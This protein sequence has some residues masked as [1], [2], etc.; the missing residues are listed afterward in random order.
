MLYDTH[1]H[2]DYPDFAN[3]LPEIIARANEA[4]VTRI[5]TIGT[6][7]ESSRRALQLAEMHPNIFA[8]IGWHPS[9]AARAPCDVRAELRALGRHEKVV[10]IG[11]IGLDYYRLPSKKEGGDAAA[12][13][14]YKAKQ[15]QVFRQQL[16]LA[17]ELGLNCV[18]HQRDSFADTIQE[19]ERFTGRIRTV[20]HC[21]AGAPAEMERVLATN[22]L[23]SFTGIVTF[24][25]AAAV[26]ETVRS[27]PTDR[28]MIETDSPF[29]APVPYRGKRCEPAYVSYV[30]ET[31]GQIKGLSVPALGEAT[32]KTAQAFFRGLK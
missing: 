8:T 19:V 2:L 3:E 10:A 32:C 1:A 22:S 24:K 13:E 25:N 7:L 27:V 21:F 14:A 26:R 6:D 31:I 16:E 20:F 28:F 15:M 4:G 29:L 30:A 23:V 17:A 5:I 12:D 9:D 18:V 11:E